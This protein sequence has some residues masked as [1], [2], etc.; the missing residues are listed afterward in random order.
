[1]SQWHSAT[2]LVHVPC[3]MC[4]AN[5]VSPTSFTNPPRKSSFIERS[6]P[7]HME[8]HWLLF[9][10]RMVEL[11]KNFLEIGQ[12]YK[13]TY[14]KLNFLAEGII[15][16]FRN[17]VQKS[18]FQVKVFPAV[19]DHC[20]FHLRTAIRTAWNNFLSFQ[21]QQSDTSSAQTIPITHPFHWCIWREPRHPHTPSWLSL[22]SSSDVTLHPSSSLR[23]RHLLQPP[24]PS[25]WGGRQHGRQR[26]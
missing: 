9:W 7:T 16:D 15:K 6:M 4:H 23:H 1:M 10:K 5:M 20:V 17:C 26:H 13:C 19:G 14:L 12:C 22:W 21:I 2:S 24:P 11:L 3:D 18:F 25:Q 8:V